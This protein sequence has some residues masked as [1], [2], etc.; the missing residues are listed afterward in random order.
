MPGA[1]RQPFISSL[2]YAQDVCRCRGI[3]AALDCERQKIM[4]RCGPCSRNRQ[5]VCEDTKKLRRTTPKIHAQIAREIRKILF[6]LFSGLL[7]KVELPSPTSVMDSQF[8]PCR[9]QTVAE[10]QQETLANPRPAA[11]TGSLPQSSQF[12]G[13][14]ARARYGLCLES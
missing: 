1:A 8:G 14:T 13:V 2:C 12:P 10:E 7:T 3:G 4:K 6:F 5:G 11:I 9:A